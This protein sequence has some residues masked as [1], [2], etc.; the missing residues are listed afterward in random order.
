MADR[1][2]QGIKAPIIYYN[3][4]NYDDVIN[5]WAAF[6]KKQHRKGLIPLFI[7]GLGV[8]K[9]G[10]NEIPDVYGIVDKLEK[11]FDRNTEINSKFPEIAELFKTLGAI[12]KEKQKDRGTIA[13]LL[14]AF[15]ETDKLKNEIWKPVTN[16]TLLSEIINA[17]PTPFHEGLADLYESFDAVNI[18][19]NF[20][21][22]LIK[23]FEVRRKKEK[24]KEKE[25]G[26]KRFFSLPVPKECEDFFLRLHDTEGT[27]DNVKEYLEIQIRGDILY[28]KC[29]S[30]TYCPNK[31]KEHSLW[32][33]IDFFSQENHGEEKRKPEDFL[34]CPY[35]GNIGFP[36]LSFPGSY[37][38]EKDMKGMLAIVWKCLA[39]RIGSITVV[40]T[41]AEWD[42]LMIAFLGDLLSERE[43][44]LLV[45]DRYPK[46]EKVSGGEE[47]PKI[48]HIIK[49]LVYTKIHDA[50]ALGVT[51]DQF[52]NDLTEKLP[53]KRVQINNIVKNK[54][55][56]TDDEYWY[57]MVKSTPLEG[58][59]NLEYSQLEN[60]VRIKLKSKGI[61]KFAQ[62]GLKS[63]WLGI[64]YSDKAK[65]HTRF[66]HSIGVM[67]VASYLYDKAIENAGLKKNDHEK[68]FLR[69]AALLH[70]IGHLPFS[71]L[72]EDVF[73]EL[74]W[75]PAGYKDHYSHEFQTDKEIEEVFNYNKQEL[76]KQLEETGYNVTDVIKLVNGSF[77]VSYLDA[78]INSSIDA[79]KIDYIFRD[80][81]STSRKTSLDP[82]Q[83]LKDI[84]NGLSITPEKYLSFSGVSAMF[85]VGLLRE[86]QRLYES[87]YLQP[88]II[89][90]E[91]IVKLIIK[92]YFVHSIELDDPEIIGKMKPND[93]DYPDLGEYKISYCVKKLQ[94]IFNKVKKNN[95]TMYEIKIVEKMF[96]EIKI[97]ENILGKKFFKNIKKGFNV[98]CDT[99]DSDVLQALEREITHKRFNDQ[100]IK[101]KEIIRD[102]MFRMPGA[103]II[104]I[105][106]LPK[107]LSSS[108]NRGKR[109]RSDGTKVFSECILV[110]KK[111]CNAWNSNDKAAV[112]I[113]D[114][115]LNDKKEDIIS[116]YMYPLSG[117]PDNNSY[118]QYTLDLFDKLL[119]ENQI[120]EIK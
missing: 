37:K 8:S 69:L 52:M 112:T 74:N 34:T 13:K 90:L 3:G 114:S 51:A 100:K 25:K 20:D 65:Y 12:R 14:K 54:S 113:H 5:Q 56:S 64:K 24:E 29:D 44:P 80:T 68:Q 89:V 9:S 110:P 16:D 55:G 88:G 43:I 96:E 32:A 2:F 18:T 7:T 66:N 15:Q 103:A 104:E 75:K 91:G 116:V 53:P 111:D 4:E 22:L 27:E 97:R 42:P 81:H 11:K 82:V 79:D 95:D 115:R 62:L 105:S 40:G 86:R 31:G 99:D 117:N 35:C 70:D 76:K 120:S 72:I 119:A 101:I 38:K 85:A 17:D 46:G 28:V 45:V 50:Q 94:E 84:V 60:N 33:S 30:K 19:L 92:T 47:K 41:S 23:E 21:G 118:Y 26:K 102:V 58:P 61:D 59:I 106:T 93:N 36:F 109:E 10:G 67:K 83:F 73:N 57:D 78:I 39:F 71:H 48:T 49:E 87:L 107:F 6:I 1:V 63:Y 98:V 77:G 108:D